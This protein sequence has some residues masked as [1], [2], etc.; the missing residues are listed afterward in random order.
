MQCRIVRA[1]L[2]GVVVLIAATSVQAASFNDTYAGGNNFYNPGANNGNVV[3]DVIGDVN[4]FNTTS[5]DVNRIGADLQVI[6][7]TNYAAH[8]NALGTGFGALF[9]SNHTIT[10]AGAAPYSGDTFTADKGR[11]EYAFTMPFSPNFNGGNTATGNG[12][13]YA[14]IGDGSDVQLSHGLGGNNDTVGTNFRNNQAVDYKGNA[15][16][17]TGHANSTWTVDKLASTIT[18]LIKN[19]NGMLGTDFALQWAMTCANDV[20]LGNVHLDCPNCGP[21]PGETP[22]PG[23]L[24][25][26]TGGLGILGLAGYRRRKRAAH[27]RR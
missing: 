1:G 21:P 19:E 17:L 2:A 20:I 9:L 5:M 7:H 23:A 14:L 24:S 11:F 12:S 10:P 27:V 18:F 26:F 22:L 3:G 25:L 8:P 4:L 6:V 16:A 13:L 15:S